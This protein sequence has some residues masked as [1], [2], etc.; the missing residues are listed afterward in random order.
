MPTDTLNNVNKD[1]SSFIN[2]TEILESVANIKVDIFSW[3][4]YNGL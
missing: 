4:A 3:N 2:K 1:I